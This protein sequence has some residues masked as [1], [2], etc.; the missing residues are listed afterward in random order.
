MFRSP[1]SIVDSEVEQVD[2]GY[3]D[4]EAVDGLM[5]ATQYDVPWREDLFTGWHFY[6]VSQC[7][8]LQRRGFITVV[9]HQRDFWCIHCPKEKP[10][11]PSYKVYNKIFLKE[12]GAE[13]D[14]EI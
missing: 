9:P 6:D 5:M 12:Y 4:V 7:K 13:L 2:F 8:E 3:I 14:P 10:L 1:V 11:D